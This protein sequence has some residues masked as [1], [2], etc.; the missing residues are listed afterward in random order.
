[1][2]EKDTSDELDLISLDVIIVWL[3]T[4]ILGFDWPVLAKVSFSPPLFSFN[5][6]YS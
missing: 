3:V 6:S 4:S 5:T 2:L 1:M